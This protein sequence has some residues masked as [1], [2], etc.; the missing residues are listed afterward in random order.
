MRNEHVFILSNLH[1]TFDFCWG[2]GEVQK[3]GWAS[4]SKG[5]WSLDIKCQSQK[6]EIW[7]SVRSLCVSVS[8]FTEKV[9][10]KP[11]SLFS[12]LSEPVTRPPHFVHKSENNVPKIKRLLLLYL[13]LL[14]T[15]TQYKLGTVT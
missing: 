11:L 9:S 10:V 8:V 4:D 14:E 1:S 15:E 3:E 2:D 13:D 7:S 6:S 5:S 12:P